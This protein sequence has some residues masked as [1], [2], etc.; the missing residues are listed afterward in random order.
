MIVNA[1]LNQNVKT[2]LLYF[3]GPHLRSYPRR[4]SD[5]VKFPFIVVWLWTL[6]T[7][8]NV[9]SERC[10]AVVRCFL[11]CWIAFLTRLQNFAEDPRRLSSQR[12]FAVFK[13]PD[14][15]VKYVKIAHT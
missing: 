9:S 11:S 1:V 13:G 5:H 7:F 15:Q 4:I 6:S 14:F 12:P 8:R 3:T 2:Y 10:A